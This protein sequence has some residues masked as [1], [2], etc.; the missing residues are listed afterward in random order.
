MHNRGGYSHI[1]A[2]RVCAAVANSSFLLWNRSRVSGSQ[3]LTPVVKLKEYPPPPPPPPRDYESIIYIFLAPQRKA[4]CFSLNEELSCYPPHAKFHH[5]PMRQSKVR[6]ENLNKR[7]LHATPSWICD[8]SSEL[9]GPFMSE[10]CRIFQ[11]T[12]LLHISRI[13]TYYIL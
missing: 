5:C 13:H 11:Q 8:G 9:S 10:S 1:W 3:R 6:T 7:D 2:T 4:F 12:Y